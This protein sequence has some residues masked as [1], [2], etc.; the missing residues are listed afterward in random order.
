M[1]SFSGFSYK[2]YCD[3]REYGV[4]MLQPK[5]TFSF[6]EAIGMPVLAGNIFRSLNRIVDLC[7]NTMKYSI[8]FTARKLF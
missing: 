8:K 1:F 3:T 2:I 6:V 5:L 4:P 7:R